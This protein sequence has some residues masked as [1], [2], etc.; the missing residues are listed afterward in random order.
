MLH[1]TVL[2]LQ[3]VLCV[4]NREQALSTQTREADSHSLALVL[5][6]DNLLSLDL[7]HG[8]FN[9]KQNSKQLAT[10]LAKVL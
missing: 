8:K 3:L 6:R 7:P 5:I 2:I 1:T 4:Y 9:Y 10:W